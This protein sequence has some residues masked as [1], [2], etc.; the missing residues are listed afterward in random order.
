M[1][2]PTPL[3]TAV[4]FIIGY[5]LAASIPVIFRNLT[6]YTGNG[7]DITTMLAGFLLTGFLAGI[8]SASRRPPGRHLRKTLIRQ[9]GISLCLALF[10]MSPLLIDGIFL[11]LNS[12]GIQNRLISN[13]LFSFFL[14]APFGFFLGHITVLAPT[15][16]RVRK[17][18]TGFAQIFLSFG[19]GALTGW[20]TTLLIISPFSGIHVAALAIMILL[21][22][23]TAL[24]N[25]HLTLRTMAIPCTVLLCS[26]ALNSGYILRGLGV[27]YTNA[28]NTVRIVTTEDGTKILYANN[29]P[30]AVID[31]ST[32]E[33]AG[34]TRQAE[35]ALLAPLQARSDAQ[36][37]DILVIGAGGFTFGLNDDRNSYTYVD[38][39]PDI[40]KASEDFFIGR[41]IG[42]NKKFRSGSA[43]DLLL[44]EIRAGKKY[45][46]IYFNSYNGEAWLPES[47]V[48]QDFFEQIRSSLKPDGIVAAH[49]MTSPYL[50]N[51]YSLYIDNTF[52]SVFPVHSRMPAARPD[53]WERSPLYMLMFLY[54]GYNEPLTKSGTILTDERNPGFW[55]KPAQRY[56]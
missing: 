2:R 22:L 31:P 41:K 46:L 10:A 28:V 32:G 16:L 19:L 48:T 29:F 55:G 49:L 24:L 1:L 40:L 18:H 11:A 8:S 13:F 52:R 5:S 26:I 38:F 45:D 47:L 6:G 56:Y 30:T 51:D 9:L 15:Y 54:I 7:T 42:P 25:K 43:R 36:T 34:T 4:L 50:M 53:P 12:I 20:L 37:K 14:L 17:I 39:D 21:T 23:A 33:S 35:D 3:P 44:D 27:T